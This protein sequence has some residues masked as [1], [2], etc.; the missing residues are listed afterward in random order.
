MKTA[1][2]DVFPTKQ[3]DT[4]GYTPEVRKATN[5]VS[6]PNRVY[7]GGV[8]QKKAKAAY[9]AGPAPTMV[10]RTV[11]TRVRGGG[12]AKFRT[13]LI[14][15]DGV[16][17]VTGTT[18]DQLLNGKSLLEAAHIKPLSK[19]RGEEYYTLDNGLLMRKDVHA[20]FD[21]ALFTINTT[22]RIEAAPGIYLDAR[23]NLYLPQSDTLSDD[24]VGFLSGHE[25]WAEE[26]WANW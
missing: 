9:A 5:A 26:Q 19:C 21:C 13:G 15:R 24:M 7:N 22:G 8:Y 14:E 3:A 23:W 6:N 16:C 4:S 20:M 11:T 10:T 1:T 17:V 18:V 25:D 2:A 12:Q